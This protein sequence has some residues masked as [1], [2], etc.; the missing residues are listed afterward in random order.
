MKTYLYA[1]MLMLVGATALTPRH[2]AAATPRCYFADCYCQDG[3]VARDMFILIPP[4]TYCSDFCP[5]YCGFAGVLACTVE[6]G[7]CAS[8][9]V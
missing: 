9:I 6:L 4:T 1:A 7:V 5:T 2:A 8:S 3:Y